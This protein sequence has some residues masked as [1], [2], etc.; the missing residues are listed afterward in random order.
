[1][2]ISL[3]NLRI[4][5]LLKDNVLIL[6]VIFIAI[7]TGL[8]IADGNL[9]YVGVIF[10]PLVIYLCIVKPFIFPFG[11]YVFLLPF[12]SILSVTG[13]VRGTTLTRLLGILTIIILL[14]KMAFEK[15]LKR[16]DSAALWWILFVIYG[17]LSWFW[18]LQPEN[19]IG[20]LTTTVGLL[21]LYLVAASYEC[22]K[23]DFDIL[24]QCILAG[25]F[26][27]AVYLLYNFAT[28]YDIGLNL[29]FTMQT[30]ARSTDPNAFAFSLLIPTAV[31]MQMIM[32]NKTMV[33][34]GL[35]IGILGV[36]L[37][38]IIITGSR[39]GFLGLAAI[40]ITY[41]LQMKKKISYGTMLII[42]GISLLS[43]TPDFFIER[44]EDAVDTGGAGRTTIWYVGVKALKDYWALGAGL[45][46]FP[47]AYNKF[48][49]IDI[50]RGFKGWDQEAHNIYLQY[51]VELGI[52]GFLLM[53]MALI[54]HYKTA[55][56]RFAEYKIDAIMLK[57]SFWAVMVSSFFLG[58]LWH[59]S[60]WLL[61]IL[62]VIQ[63]NVV[64]KEV[65][66]LNT[67]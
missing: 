19:V 26:F 30:G 40:F 33:R 58:T 65:D 27:A 53:V 51:I 42:L 29:R 21:A 67:H 16:P 15:K 64:D 1:M 7:M 5:N 4:S 8:S 47:M 28:G 61:W 62:I 44:W 38:S 31:C 55:S 35:F 34:K 12:D 32:K 54:K 23:S 45:N 52:I 3:N 56:K 6:C 43:F 2:N 37:F 49:F 41:L 46:N 24:K 17:E 18:A 39:G 10:I 20:N 11:A 59:K 14:F 66:D 13:S 63:K 60:F 57:A 22:Q 48:A 25:G 36:I 50:S 9:L